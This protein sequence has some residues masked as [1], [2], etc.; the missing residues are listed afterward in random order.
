MIDGSFSKDWV[1]A[2]LMR[3][4]LVLRV[5]EVSATMT[6]IDEWEGEAEETGKYKIKVYMSCLEAFS[7][8]DLRKKNPKF[9]YS[10]NALI[11]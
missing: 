8:A 5:D 7:T 11:R 4:C 1:T 3:K 2:T 10:L 6:G 9:D